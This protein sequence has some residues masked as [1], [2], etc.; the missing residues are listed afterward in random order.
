MKELTALGCPLLLGTSRKSVVSYCLTGDNT[1]PMEDRVF[2]TAATVAL[3]IQN[4]ADIVRVHDVKEMLQTVK[5]TDKIVG[6]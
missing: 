2:G 1:A 4:G 6:R 3:G 5:I